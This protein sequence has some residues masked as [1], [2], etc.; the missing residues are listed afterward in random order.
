MCEVADAADGRRRVR[1]A[2]RTGR[3]YMRT[4]NLWWLLGRKP[5][6]RNASVSTAA[7]TALDLYMD[8]LVFLIIIIIFFSPFTFLYFCHV[9]LV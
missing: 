9:V 8:G 7:P 5:R 3:S 6:G 2:G 4:R 1:A